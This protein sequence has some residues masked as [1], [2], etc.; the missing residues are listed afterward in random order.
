MAL[1][2]AAQMSRSA[3]RDYSVLRTPIIFV[4]LA[5]GLTI[6]RLGALGMQTVSPAVAHTEGVKWVDAAKTSWLPNDNSR[7]IVYKFVADWSDP[8]KRMEESALSNKQVVKLIEDNFQPVRIVDV[9]RENGKNPQWLAD[10]EKKYR[11]FALPT[12]V[13]VDGNGEQLAAQIGSCSSLSTY[14]FL[15]RTVHS[16]NAKTQP[17]KLTPSAHHRSVHEKTASGLVTSTAK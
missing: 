4:V 16:I 13:I 5:V 6:L 14:R 17:E 2:E 9:A 12:L 7:P 1:T 8:C 15:T 10:M 3:Q 11:V